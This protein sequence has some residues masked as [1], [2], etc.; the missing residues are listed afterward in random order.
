MTEDKTL[1]PDALPIVKEKP[2]PPAKITVRLLVK[3]YQK[4]GRVYQNVNDAQDV[5]ILADAPYTCVPF[6]V[7][8]SD[9]KQSELVVNDPAIQIAINLVS[10]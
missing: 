9:W 6:S 7:S 5:R 1:L 4:R 8:A 2:Q 10:R 3:N